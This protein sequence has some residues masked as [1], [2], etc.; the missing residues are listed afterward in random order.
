MNNCLKIIALVLA[1]L[2]INQMVRADQAKLENG[3]QLFQRCVACHLA[4]AQGVP[5]MFPPLTQR[6]GVLVESQAGRDYLVMVINTGIAGVIEVEGKTYSNIMPAQASGLRDESIASVLNY[7]LETFNKETLPADW[8]LF[9]AREVRS[10]KERYP[11]ANI[12]TIHQL[13]QT[14]DDEL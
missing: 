12:Q 10:I 9:S 1:S 5:G 13:R 7:L 3:K 11:K 6:L 8:E 14:V 4:T 2:F